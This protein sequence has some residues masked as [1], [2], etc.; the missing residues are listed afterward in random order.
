VKESSVA[1]EYELVKCGTAN[2]NMNDKS[3]IEAFGMQEYMC[4]KN[5]SYE[6]EGAKNTEIFK[7]LEV[8]LHK[9]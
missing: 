7:Y 4:I 1:Y 6:L 3:E 8:K 2:F 5:K 9:C